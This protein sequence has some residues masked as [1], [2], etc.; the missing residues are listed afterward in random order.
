MSSHVPE[1]LLTAFVDGDIEEG[2]ALH[3]AEHLDIC[4]ACATH[5]ATIE[6]LAFAFAAVEDPELPRSLVLDVLREADA[7]E[8]APLT[9]MTLGLGLLAAAGVTFALFGD[10]VG[11]AVQLSL[12]LGAAAKMGT[13]ASGTVAASLVATCSAAA[14]AMV[15]SWAAARATIPEWRL[16]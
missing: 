12:L 8:A 2:L 6:P 14:T 15:C 9:E 5:A 13:V 3:I 10:P 16:S 4:P 11:S 1:D 7:P